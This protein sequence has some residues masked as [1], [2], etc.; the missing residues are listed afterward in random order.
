MTNREFARW[1]AQIAR[2]SASW[3]HDIMT[4]GTEHWEKPTLGDS[5]ERF[6][7]E[8]REVLEWMESTP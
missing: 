4:T 7:R 2:R 1:T 8:I 6:C 3:T 5:R